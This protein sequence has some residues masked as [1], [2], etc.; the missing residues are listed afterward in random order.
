[1]GLFNFIKNLAGSNNQISNEDFFDANG[2]P[3]FIHE[4]LEKEKAHQLPW[5]STLTA[6]ELGLVKNYG[7]KMLGPLTS[8]CWLHYGYSWTEG[9][10]QGWQKALD[11]MKAEALALG[12]NAVIDVKMVTVK[13]SLSDS[14]DFSLVGTAVS[15]EGLPASKDPIISTVPA[16][17]FAELLQAGIVP[18]GIAIGARYDWT[19]TSQVYAGSGTISWNRNNQPLMD[20]TNFW[21]HTRRKAHEDLRKDAARQGMGVLANL[22]FSQLFRI[23]R[24]NM[25]DRILG[26]HIVIGTVVDY[27]KKLK[28]PQKIQLVLDMSDN[29]SFTTQN[30]HHTSYADGI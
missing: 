2:V 1:M 29:D 24:E 15:I 16:L 26:R 22:N 25:P 20:L 27:D 17:E 10:A 18:V 19:D 23:E 9:H 6:S 11:R 21:E 30:E 14:M 4:K 3:H 7:F 28:V 5:V 8:S 13:M 12:A